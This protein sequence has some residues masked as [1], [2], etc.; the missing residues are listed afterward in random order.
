MM[1]SSAASRLRS[2]SAIA[3]F[4]YI[5]FPCFAWER[6]HPTL[7]VQHA[8]CDFRFYAVR[9]REAPRA[10]VATRS[11]VTRNYW[12]TTHDLRREALVRRKPLGESGQQV[13]R[14]IDVV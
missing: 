1:S 8:E 10:R 5:S 11:I 4:V 7:R 12:Y 13:G 9:G 6:R 2:Y 14:P 3:W